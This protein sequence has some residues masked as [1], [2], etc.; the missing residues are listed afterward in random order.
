MDTTPT[1]RL[2]GG[3]KRGDTASK[4]H[5]NTAVVTTRGFL[6]KGGQH[7]AGSGSC[8]Q[9]ESRGEWPWFSLWLEVGLSLPGLNCQVGAPGGVGF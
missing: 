9:R 7:Q 3:D 1:D 5:E 4:G 6:G 8:G 2:G